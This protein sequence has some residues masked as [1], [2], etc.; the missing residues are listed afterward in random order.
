MTDLD[1]ITELDRRMKE[2]WVPLF[3]AQ[4]ELI[5]DL[6]DDLD[7]VKAGNDTLIKRIGELEAM[8]RNANLR[9]RELES[10]ERPLPEPVFYN[11]E[12]TSEQK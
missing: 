11:R 8:L 3:Q 7:R 6:T 9:I 5:E 2:R 12:V 1:R 10:G 4:L